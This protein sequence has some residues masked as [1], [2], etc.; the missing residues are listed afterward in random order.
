MTKA[1]AI[2]EAAH[3]VRV[4]SISPG[5]ILTPLWKSAAESSGNAAAAL[6]SGAEAQCLGRFGTIDECGETCL[7]LASEAS[8]CTGIDIILSGGAELGYAKK[9]RL[10]QPERVY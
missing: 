9:T 2:D 3:G 7:F 1:L 4:N 6:E 10:E 8:Y 5:N